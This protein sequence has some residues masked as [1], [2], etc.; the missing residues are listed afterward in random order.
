M[1]RVFVL[2]WCVFVLNVAYGQYVSLND[3]LQS[4]GHQVAALLEGTKN[5]EAA[6]FGQD[7]NTLWPNSFSTEQQQLIVDIAISIQDRKLGSIPY[8][9]DFF[10]G[11]TMGVNL[12]G[13]SDTKLDNY[14]SMIKQSLDQNSIR[15]FARELVTL[16]VFF[17]HQALHRTSFNSLYVLNAEYDF[18]YIAAAEE[19]SYE[20]IIADE[21][22]EEEEQQED[23]D[24]GNENDGWGDEV[25]DGWGDD[26]SGWGEEDGEDAWEDDEDAWAVEEDV[27]V[28]E[29]GIMDFQET[30][31][32]T[33]LPPKEGAVIHFERI[34]LVFV[35]K[36]DSTA[37]SGTKGTY[38]LD[39]YQFVGEGGR[40]DWSSAG[41]DPDEVYVNLDVF[42]FNTRNPALEA[43]NA[44]LN[45]PEKTSAEVNGFFEFKSVRHDSLQDA[46]YPKFI[47]Y[48]NDIQLDNLGSENLIYVGGI[49]LEGNKIL[50]ASAYGLESTLKYQDAEG[51]KF[52]TISR[53]YNFQDT[54][55][56]SFNS[57]VSVYHGR[58]SIFHPSVKARYYTNS[59]RFVAIKDKNGFNFRPFDAS[60][61][62]MSVEADAIDW[63]MNSDSLNIAIINAR[64]L[65]P[66][67]FKSK[68]Y[69]DFE[70]I[71]ELTG[72]YNFNPLMVAYSYGAKNKTREFYV[73]NL[74]DDLNLNDKAVRGAMKHLLYLD[75]IEYDEIGGRIY[76]KDKALHFVRSKN[77]RKDYDDLMIPSLSVDN[78]NATL[79]LSSN[80]LT[81]RG[82]DKFFI[83]EILDVYIFPKDKE[84][85]LLKNRD[86]QFDGQLFAGN[87]EFVGR[88]FTFRYDSF[89]VDLQNIDSVKFYI[90]GDGLNEKQEVD[91]KLVSIESIDDES[92]KMSTNSST[93]GTL[94]IN[95]PDNK[96]GRK[97]FPQ[98][99]NFNADRGAIVYFDDPET[100]DGA[101]D[102]S[103]YF[104]VP[105]F[106][107]DSLS[108]SDP[109]TIGFEG[110][111]ITGGILPEFKQRL[112]IMPDNSLGFEHVLPQE[113][114]ELYGGPGRIYNKVMLDKN[115]IVG[116][117]KID[118]L[119]SSSYS[120]NYVFYLDSMVAEGTNFKL[121]EGDFDGVSYPDIYTDNF[122]MTWKPSEDHMYVRNKLDS[123][124][125][126]NNTAYFDGEIDLASTGVYGGGKMATRGFESESEE[127]AFSEYNLEAKHATFKLESDNPEKPLLA[128]DDIRLEF[129]FSRD[130]ADISPEIEGMAALDFPY[131][132][133]KTSISKA[134]W[135]LQEQK[136]YMTKPPD[137]AIENSY[138]YATREELDS[139]AFN[140]E[141]AE[142]DLQSSQLKVS[143]IPYIIVADAM[144]TPEN[145]EVLILENAQ[146]GEMYNT[147]IVIDTLNE[148]HR[149]IDGT[150]QIHSRKDFTGDATYEFVNALK[151]TFNIK[152]GKFELWKDDEIRNAPLQ[153]VSSG[154]ISENDRL[155]ISEGLFY[156]GDV[157]MYARNKA[158][159]LEGFVQFDFK[160][161]PDYNT[162]IRYRSMDEETQDVMFDFNTAVTEEGNSLN[163]G[164]HFGSLNNEFYA[165]FAEE[166][167]LDTDPDFFKAN[168]IV[169]FNSEKGMFMVE[170]TAKTNGSKFSGKVFGYNDNTGAIEFEGPLNF[171]ES[172]ENASLIASGF[173]SGNLNSGNYQ[174]NSLLKVDYKLPDQAMTVMAADLFEVIE[175]FGAPEAENDPDAFLYKVS[176]LIGERATIEYDNRSQE[177]YLPISAFTPKMAGSLVF[178]KVMMAWSPEHKAWYS[179]DKVGLSNILKYDINASI[180][181]FIEIKRDSERGTIM[182]MFIQA[183]SDCWYYFGFEDNRLMIYSSND[184]FVDI[185]ASKSN[186][187]KAGFGEYVFVNADLPDVL[188]FVDRFRLQYLGIT[189][190][191]EI[192]MPTEE[193]SD[194]FDILEIPVDNTEDGDVL[195]ADIVDNTED[196]DVL[197]M[198]IVDNT[199]E[200]LN[201]I[202]DEEKSDEDKP[203]T[204]EDLLKPKEEKAEEEEE[205]DDE[206]F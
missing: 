59:N 126:Y 11:L 9:R 33:P 58:D 120:D 194:G 118:Y 169:Y 22:E 23:D 38:L 191:Y 80:E 6:S 46:R 179:T 66:A 165:T 149:L 125:L 30:G 75:F 164:L 147:T 20:E 140:A 21:A 122:D 106:G 200:S 25:D 129:D 10:G 74:I 51:K 157:T 84:I 16:R 102:K 195:P 52:K 67:Y 121:E 112:K 189:D 204:E 86:F 172:T 3:S 42:S 76:L 79:N 163:A 176:E 88:N 91:N 154:F 105:P 170:D 160:S 181:G 54:I 113:G 36:Y 13:L 89:L 184:E 201:P 4:F 87:F 178:S 155:R 94:Y 49:A 28:S 72:V 45:Y 187:D 73:S 41:R 161:R 116:S 123:F 5:A 39:K 44:K 27:D 53:L 180:D 24:W 173:G 70:E 152:F 63:D 199:E 2:L 96:S 141:A 138:F 101:Y 185:I 132:Q 82:I 60:Y 182:N 55:I 47:S 81:V 196:D 29:S 203:V 35:T 19:M 206:G 205:E 95:R 64:S 99:P 26:E 167:R 124:K 128:G 162:W 97:I 151:D 139:L 109:K 183:S 190:P 202:E 78:P 145:N 127:F 65:L 198:D 34:D 7:F 71:K 77:N 1:R 15:N 110:T 40:F 8:H 174:V 136:V 166:K 171:V 134:Q 98:Y 131:A 117:G 48:Q 43:S 69:Y 175:N 146:I 144:I 62:N 177:D 111:F 61:Y 50:G 148:Y 103:V 119:S 158:L 115:G 186:I 193:I 197:P 156:K 114:F 150:I 12:T 188:K 14:L 68:E 31:M 92:V 17:E 100:L 137:V 90:D 18:E 135:N 107:I 37:L 83:S 104:V 85:N 108:S 192:S 56:T 93:S 159:E 142:Y 168:G 133:I 130:V 143:G 32:D 57:I 153:T